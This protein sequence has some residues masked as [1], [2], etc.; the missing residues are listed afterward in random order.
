MC[1][2]MFTTYIHVYSHTY[3]CLSCAQHTY[4]CTLIHTC[5]L[6]CSPHTYMCTLMHR[7]SFS[8]DSA[9]T[10]TSFPTLSDHTRI[11]REFQSF[12]LCSDCS[13]VW[14]SRCGV[15]FVC[16]QICICVCV[17][18]QKCV[19]MCVQYACMCVFVC[20]DMSMRV[21]VCAQ[22]SVCLSVCLCR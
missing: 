7:S 6:S 10:W 8:F 17:C 11:S 19:C 18:V 9:I 14:T 3:M 21:L 12:Y 5:I 16:V 15:L 1:T 4:M 22:V 20:A 2:F 13:R